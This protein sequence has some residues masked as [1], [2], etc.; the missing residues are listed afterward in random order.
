MFPFSGIAWRV[1]YWYSATPGGYGVEGGE[2][3][4]LSGGNIGEGKREGERVI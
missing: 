1:G 2:L 3:E 4:G